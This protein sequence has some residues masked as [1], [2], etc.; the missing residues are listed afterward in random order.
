MKV[1]EMGEACSRLRGGEEIYRQYFGGKGK[2]V[3]FSRYWPR[4][5]PSRVSRGI[6]LPFLDRG[7]R[8]G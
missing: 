1:S 4:T 5:W 3:K 6:A 2:K 8:R 7:I